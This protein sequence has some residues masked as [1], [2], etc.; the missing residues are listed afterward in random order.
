ML[1]PGVAM[2]SCGTAQGDASNGDNDNAALNPPA[3][4]SGKNEKPE[5]R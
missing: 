4:E 2:P 3:S 1:M 5:R